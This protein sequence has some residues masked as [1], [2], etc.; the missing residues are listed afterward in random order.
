MR[1]P[2]LVE[3]VAPE[4]VIA[5]G[6]L[7]HRGRREQHER[8]AAFLRSIGP[9]V[10]AVPGNHDI[11]YSFPARLASPWREFERVWETVE[12]VYASATAQVVGL[13]SVRPAR[14]QSGGLDDAQLQ[15]AATRLAEGSARRA[16]RRRVPPPADQC[17]VALAQEAGGAAGTRALASSSRRAPS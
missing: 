8:A 12:P 17:A 3:R 15:R 2:A 14:H 13:N 7:T 10:L 1:W 16:P 6:D 9:P 11:P 5:S 4:L